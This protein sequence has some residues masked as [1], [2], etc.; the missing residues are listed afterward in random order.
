MTS[1][2]RAQKTHTTT[3][4]ILKRGYETCVIHFIL[5]LVMTDCFQSELRTVTM[6]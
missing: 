1:F 5:H 2:L 4:A 3:A 6:L